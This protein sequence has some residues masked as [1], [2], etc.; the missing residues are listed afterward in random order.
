MT[1]ELI[2]YAKA[3]VV[4]RGLSQEQFTPAICGEVMQEAIRRMDRLTTEVLEGRTDR[5]QE[6]VAGMA[7]QIYWECR[8]NRVGIAA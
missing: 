6:V 2:S 5:A 7:K 4:E 8:L 3:I 1:L